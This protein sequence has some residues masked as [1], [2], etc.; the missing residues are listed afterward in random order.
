MVAASRLPAH[1]RAAV[2]G[3][4]GEPL[5]LREYPL[6][7]PG[8]GEL[9]MRVACAAVCGSD[10]HA[11][12]GALAA[13]FSIDLPIV[14]G[15][16]T[17]G[18]VVAVGEGADRDALGQPVA[19]GD[20]VVWAHAAC[21]QC[22]ACT[23][24]RLG[25]LCPNRQ[26]GF[27]RNAELAPHFHGGFAEYAHIPARARR[28]RVPDDVKTEWAAAASCALRTVVDAVERLG[29]VDYRHSI[30]IQGAGPLGLF[31][32]AMLAL[33]APRRIIVIGGPADRLAVAQAWGADT[34]I[35]VAEA[36]TPEE[37]IALVRDLT[38][39]RGADVVCELSGARTAFA[40]GL[41]MAAPAG[42]YLIAGTLGSTTHPV[43]AGLITRR[44]L[45]V[46][47]SLG[48]EIDAYH[49]AMEVLRRHRDRFDWD[50]LIGGRYRLDDA[51]T[52]LERMRDFTE[53]KA[54][55]VP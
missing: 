27:L 50:L 2:V 44:N 25:T 39:G 28:L 14:L 21:G 11:W 4:W 10:V 47:G 40:E 43:E 52:A 48:A 22:H 41:E 30:V 53:T 45:T 18:R 49:K 6:V 54:V 12:D 9:V 55:I 51:T 38:D 16:E 5:E 23:V 34:T 17:V 35:D 42:R 29:P 33:H 15:H 26:I 37:R 8:P 13:S 24:L 46:I 7:A 19:I 31:A 20:R 3:A 36:T 1:G 32:T